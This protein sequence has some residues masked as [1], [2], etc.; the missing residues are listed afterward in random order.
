[1]NTPRAAAPACQCD[2]VE[3]H[4]EVMIKV[5]GEA[6]LRVTDDF[7]RCLADAVGPAK[8]LVIDLTAVT[9]MDASGYRTIRAAADRLH[10]MDLTVTVVVSSPL[11]AE[12]LQALAGQVAR[13]QMG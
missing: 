5:T 8:P 11:A 3:L 2:V 6:D 10:S 4:D 7:R 9:F 12:V 1:M 13:V